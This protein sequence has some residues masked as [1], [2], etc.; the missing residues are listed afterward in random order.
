MEENAYLCIIDM[1]NLNSYIKYFVDD[2][3]KVIDIA[4][5]RWNDSMAGERM[6]GTE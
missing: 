6:F 3:T 1:I 2:E 5:S 4:A